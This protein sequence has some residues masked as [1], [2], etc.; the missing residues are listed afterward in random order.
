MVN[1]PKKKNLQKPRTVHN[2]KIP[3]F[4]KLQGL[5]LKP[6]CDAEFWKGRR[7]E[8]SADNI[9]KE[10]GSLCAEWDSITDTWSFNGG[11]G[12]QSERVFKAL[13]RIAARGLRGL[14]ASPPWKVWLD[15]M[16]N[17]KC[18]FRIAGK[19]EETFSQ[20]TLNHFVGMGMRP[21]VVEGTTERVFISKAVAA[22]TKKDLGITIKPGRTVEQRTFRGIIGT[23]ERLFKTS[24]EFCLELEARAGELP[25][26]RVRKGER[27]GEPVPDLDELKRRKSLTQED[28]AKAF[29]VVSR[30]IRNWISAGKLAKTAK[31]RIAVD[32][33]FED[34]F[35][36][37]HLSAYQM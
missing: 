35:K 34:L 23:I 7:N 3:D 9:Q 25:G 4:D 22:K 15:Y 37:H 36:K 24:A 5:S 1:P 6:K 27:A 13:A 11:S 12:E 20:P 14:R 31:G 32:Q 19:T 18:G 21:P 10:H 29:G 17:E 26:K 2:P 28:A 16:R 8:F 33:K 30:T